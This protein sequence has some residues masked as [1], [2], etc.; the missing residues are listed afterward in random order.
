MMELADGLTWYP[1]C[2]IGEGVYGEVFRAINEKTGECFALKKIKISDGDAG[3]PSN[4]VRE[5]GLLRELDHVNVVKLLDVAYRKIRHQERLLLVFEYIDTDLD[6]AIVARKKANN[7]ITPAESCDIVRQLLRGLK[8]CHSRKIIHRDIKPPNIL[9]SRNG[10]VKICDFG[11]SRTCITPQRTLTREV[12]TLW[13]RAPEILLGAQSYTSVIDVWSVG[14]IMAELLF[15]CALFKGETE[16]G[17]IISIFQTMGTPT[18]ATWPGVD[19]LPYFQDCFP[20]W[21]P[22]DLGKTLGISCPLSA[23]FLTSILS[24]NPAKRPAAS[25]ALRHAALRKTTPF[26]P[27]ASLCHFGETSQHK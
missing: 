20:K 12:V 5:I 6:S 16:F 23:D 10:V 26:I 4:T 3:M 8:Y 27:D 19:Q 22:L 14:C 15:M 18:T 9:V 13:Y 21:S 1:A 7:P 24:L 25:I 17:Q 11:I 2:K